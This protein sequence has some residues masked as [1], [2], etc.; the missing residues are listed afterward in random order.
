MSADEFA[1]IDWLRQRARPKDARV[2]IGIGDDMAAIRWPGGLVLI[3]CD[4]RLDTVH[5]V[6]A[7]HGPELV[8]RKVITCGLSDCAAMA[9]LPR[10]A[11]VSVALNK[12]VTMDEAQRLAG[13]MVHTAK[14]YGCEIVGGDTT[15][16]TGPTAIDVAMLG[17]VPDRGQPILRSG[18]RPGDAVYVTGKLGGSILGRHMTFEPRV[19]LAQELAA[20]GCVHAMIDISDGLAADLKHI[21]EE[22]HCGAVLEGDL[23]EKV[24]HDDAHRLSTQ[25]N[26]PPLDHALHDGEDFELVV[27][28][29]ARGLQPLAEDRTILLIGKI[30]TD[31]GLR[32]RQD[33][34]ERPLSPAGWRHK[35]GATT[36]GS[37]QR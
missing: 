36:S 26:Q 30:T 37:S 17:E 12:N 9:A 24:I 22:S 25:D 34:Q 6:W 18:A 8:G 15:S 14:T 2:A 1:F 35:F 4:I 3:T 5:F 19:K 23:L 20:T 33:H 10:A 21:C 7:Q 27:V 28:G 29:D 13:S 31:G 32:I 11:V 16:W